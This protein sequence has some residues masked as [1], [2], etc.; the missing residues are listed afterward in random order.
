MTDSEKIIACL[1]GNL[2][3]I[4]ALI[5]VPY[6]QADLH[7]KALQVRVFEIGVKLGLKLHSEKHRDQGRQEMLERLSELLGAK[8]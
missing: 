7:E 2:D 4:L 5:S 1:G 6:D 8:K 3:N